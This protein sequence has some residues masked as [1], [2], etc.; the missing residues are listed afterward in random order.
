MVLVIGQALV[1]KIRSPPFVK[2]RT[3]AA[4]PPVFEAL[5]LGL[6]GFERV[7]AVGRALLETAFAVLFLVASDEALRLH[8]AARYRAAFEFLSAFIDLRCE[9]HHQAAGERKEKRQ[10]CFTF[11]ARILSGL[12]QTR[13]AKEQRPWPA[14]FRKPR[15]HLFPAFMVS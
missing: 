12:Y 13:P 3:C 7:I 5:F 8:I 9:Y 2:W 14:M 10:T 1:E 4:P 11:H 6:A 15:L